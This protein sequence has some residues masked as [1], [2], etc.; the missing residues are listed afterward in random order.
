M[1]DYFI[2]RSCA[3]SS[4]A[5]LCIKKLVAYHEI[6]GVFVEWFPILFIF[7]VLACMNGPP[8]RYPDEVAIGR[9]SCYSCVRSDGEHE[10]EGAGL[11]LLGATIPQTP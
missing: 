3:T 8:T 7:K 1:Q 10:E 4:L 9:S 5:C 2:S 6:L 11:V